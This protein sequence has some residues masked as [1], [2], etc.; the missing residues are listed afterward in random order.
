[1]ILII[2]P[3]YIKKLQ[4]RKINHTV[5]MLL[6]AGVLCREFENYYRMQY[7]KWKHFLKKNLLLAFFFSFYGEQILK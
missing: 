6:Y 3:I 1:M 2:Y 4:S 7:Y 5:Q